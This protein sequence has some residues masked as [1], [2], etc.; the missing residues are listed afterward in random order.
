MFSELVSLLSGLGYRVYDSD[1]P[2]QPEFPYIVVWGGDARPHIEA[3][4]ASQIMGVQDRVGVTCAAGTPEGARI[5]H[6]LTRGLL[7][8]GGFP[9]MVG[10]FMLKLTDHQPV[11]VDRQETIT[12]TN[13][14]PAF[15]VDI[16]SASR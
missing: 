11:E 4:L 2:E 6:R 10:G 12:G 15:T 16:Y 5:V 3:P 14:H 8:P 7:Q 13:R 1:V 9:K